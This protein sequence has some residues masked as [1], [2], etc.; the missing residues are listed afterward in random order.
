MEK[1]SDIFYVDKINEGE[2]CAQ[3]GLITSLVKE[4]E[5]LYLMKQKQIKLM[6]KFCDINLLI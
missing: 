3:H 2:T 6:A 1:I 5:K 4:N